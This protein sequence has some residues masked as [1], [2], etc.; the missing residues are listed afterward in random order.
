[1]N[2]LVT[3]SNGYV[4]SH[5]V[6][7]LEEC[8]YYVTGFDFLV[9][10]SVS[11]E[12]Q[13]EYVAKLDSMLR[14]SC[15]DVIIHLGAIR[16]SLSKRPDIMFW[17]YQATVEI[18]NRMTLRQRL[19]YFSSCLA[20]MPL[21]SYGWSK[22]ASEQYIEATHRNHVILRPFNIYGGQEVAGKE[23]VPTLLANRDLKWVFTDIE[24]DYIH[25]QDVVRSVQH[26][27]AR[28][29]LDG[30]F[31]VGTGKSVSPCELADLLGW[32]DATKVLRKMLD[33]DIP[34]KMVAESHLMLPDF[35]PQYD[36]KQWYMR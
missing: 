15:Y 12:A 8:G 3:G 34:A 6:P 21:N 26:V 17:N 14:S 30:T 32:H 7:I 20:I 27:I 19:I 25:V 31:E 16:D 33:A 11:I 1:M 22:K 18:S 35:N 10:E 13:E 36:I 5:L 23:S 4:G 2:I 9:P 24:R 28:V 29:D